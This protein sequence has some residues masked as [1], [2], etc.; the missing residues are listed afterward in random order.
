MSDV[1][2]LLEF[3]RDA[4]RA[5]VIELDD[6]PPIYVHRG[7]RYQQ[8][9]PGIF[10]VWR[11]HEGAW[12]PQCFRVFGNRLPIFVP[13]QVWERREELCTRYL[14]L[15]E[16]AEV[17]PAFD[18]LQVILQDAIDALGGPAAP[19]AGDLL[20]TLHALESLG[21]MPG[22]PETF[23][24]HALQTHK[25]RTYKTPEAAEKALAQ[26]RKRAAAAVE[27]EAN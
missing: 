16:A 21:W 2:E 27:A 23:V 10:W 17:D 6:E 5:H 19:D 15:C 22:T 14:E 12:R 1:I 4:G 26:K 25:D 20:T 18:D 8:G 7:Y 9:P 24:A 13:D 3:F 11:I